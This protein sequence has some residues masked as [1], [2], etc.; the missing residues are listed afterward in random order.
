MD[1]GCTQA[2]L[3]VVLRERDPSGVG[4]P[5]RHGRQLLLQLLEWEPA[6]RLTA[7]TALA[8]PYFTSED[9]YET[10]A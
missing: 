10:G 6:N 8:H 4:L 9:D 2:D 5:S 1:A 7:A 3:A